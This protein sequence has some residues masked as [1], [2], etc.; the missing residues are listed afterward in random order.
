MPRKASS[1][2][3]PPRKP[4]VVAVFNTS[5]DLVDENLAGRDKTIYEIVGKPFDLGRLVRAVKEAARQRP[6]H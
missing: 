4:M 5:P 2:N 6:S 1:R 3:P